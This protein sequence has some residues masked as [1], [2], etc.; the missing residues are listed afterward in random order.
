LSNWAEIKAF[1]NS[2][3]GKENFLSIDELIMLSKEYIVP[4]GYNGTSANLS[5]PIVSWSSESPPTQNIKFRSYANGYV[6][7]YLDFRTG[8]GSTPSISIFNGENL[9]KNFSGNVAMETIALKISKGDTITVSFK[10]ANTY[11]DGGTVEIYGE[12]VDHYGLREV[13]Q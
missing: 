3:L 2:D 8:T 4:V 13:H 12:L 10:N 7:M 9:V 11:T 6:L 1:V 5:N